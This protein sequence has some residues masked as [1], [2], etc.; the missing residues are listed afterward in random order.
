MERLLAARDITGSREVESFLQ[1][2][3]QNIH[4]PF[5]LLGM[6]AAVDAILGHVKK[7]SRIMVHGDYDVDGITATATVT[8]FLRRIGADCRFYIPDRLTEGYGLSE[9]GIEAAAFDGCGLVVTVDCGIS[10]SDE[11][12]VLSSRGIDTVVTDHHECKQQIPAD[13]RAVV[14]PR[15]PGETYPFMGLAGAG[16]A[17]KLVHA[18]CIRLD[19]GDE[20]RDYLDFA[21]LGTMADVMPLI[22]ENRV[23]VHFGIQSIQR[24]ENLGITTMLR[25]VNMCNKPVTSAM[26][27]FT[28]A[29]RLN[30][31]GR[32]GNAARAVELLL[33]DSLAIADPLAQELCADNQKRKD[34]ENGI[35]LEASR[36]IDETFDFS[37]GGVIVVHKE[38]W[39]Q[40]IIGIVASRLA[41]T[42]CRPAIVLAGE[43][44]FYRGSSRS[45]GD[46]NMLG[47]ITAA[48]G[49]IMKFGG[50]R[51]ACGMMIAEDQLEEFKKKVN[52]YAAIHLDPENNRHAIQI[53][54][55]LEMP[56][57]TER[58][59]RD[60]AVLSP[61]GEGNREPVFVTENLLVKEMWMLGNGHHLKLMVQD[62]ASGQP[63][64]AIGFGMDIFDGLVGPG[65][66]VDLAYSLGINHWEGRESLQ[67]KILDIRPAG[68]VAIPEVDL[69]MAEADK[70]CRARTE[71][72]EAIAL[73]HGLDLCR[74]IPPKSEFTSVYQYVKAN[75]SQD[76]LLCDLTLLSRKISRSYQLNL[77]WFR[78]SRILD[79]FDEASLIRQQVLGRER[80]HIT[81]LPSM[82]K[83]NLH[84]CASFQFLLAAKERC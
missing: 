80:R 16:V 23:L 36:M 76:P 12:S 34:V 84:A 56:M 42:F 64:A 31:A 43:D 1:P 50:H 62:A 17:L 41:E 3:L 38:G 11:I 71:P 63:V 21:A 2:S 59:A 67:L 40:G 78:L 33:T 49:H 5:L 69:R 26:V 9:S 37:G 48:S 55:P 6:D 27:G 65:D 66:R 25:Y 72:L 61:F 68:G 70:A 22:G 35:I 7:G 58:N 73:R 51:K 14:N 45:F 52:A 79:V 57:V 47:A 77:D 18:L 81:V 19:R 13:A 83:A 20:W 54:M 46:F 39:H 29:P 44:G 32:M 74:L 30:A 60:I 53:D 82:E 28:L 8:A 15:Q 10:G 75:F 4:D 24:Q